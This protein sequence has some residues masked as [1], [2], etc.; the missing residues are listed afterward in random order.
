MEK[1]LIVIIL[2]EMMHIMILIQSK[3]SPNCIPMFV[4][5]PCS[6]CQFYMA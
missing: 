2:D 6:K 5:T 1:V 3:S 4:G